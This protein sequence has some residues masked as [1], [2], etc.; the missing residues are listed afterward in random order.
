MWINAI[1]NTIE[2]F[3]FTDTNATWLEIQAGYKN[4]QRINQSFDKSMPFL[5]FVILKQNKKI[6][7]LISIFFQNTH[8][9]E[10]TLA[11][12]DVFFR[13]RF[14]VVRTHKKPTRKLK[15][16]K[17]IIRD[18][19]LLSIVLSLPSSVNKGVVSK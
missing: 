6:S 17:Q 16:N 11:Y 8:C 9:L 5:L 7:I 2:P 13:Y 18:P 4:N 14:L 3:G 10:Y 15:Q 19:N 12:H 1:V